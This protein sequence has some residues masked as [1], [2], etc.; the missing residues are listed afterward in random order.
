M[1]YLTNAHC[2]QL[3]YFKIFTIL[4][5]ILIWSFILLLFSLNRFLEL[6]LSLETTNIFKVL[7]AQ[8]QIASQ[9]A[10][11]QY[12]WNICIYTCTHTHMLLYLPVYVQGSI[13]VDKIYKNVICFFLFNFIFVFKWWIR[14]TMIYSIFMIQNVTGKHG[15]TREIK[16]SSLPHLTRCIILAF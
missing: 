8:F 14:N 15:E 6:K 2:W 16:Q 1:T 11:V 10:Y 12:R 3:D 4:K 7:S 5:S 13:I 9:K